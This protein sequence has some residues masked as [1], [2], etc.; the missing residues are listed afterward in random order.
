L[1]LVKYLEVADLEVSTREAHEGCVRRTS[2]PVLG[3]S[4]VWLTEFA[5]AAQNE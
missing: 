2:G 5:S 4:F 1:A 3:R